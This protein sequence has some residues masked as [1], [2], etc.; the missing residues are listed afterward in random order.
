MT[1]LRV[2]VL[3]RDAKIIGSLVGGCRVTI[4]HEDT[5]Q[6]LARGLHLGGSGETDLIMKTPRDRGAG[7]VYDSPG[8]AC[9]EARL[10]LDGPTPIRVD[11][12]GPLA[13]PHA[14][15]RASKTLWMIPGE[16]IV[17]EG[18]LLELNGFIV[19]IL[20]PTGVDVLHSRAVVPVRAGV[21]LL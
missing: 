8:T 16:D 9:Y 17:G 3:S 20:Q 15:Q 2:R 4:R 13:F 1:R 18:L 12:E 14:I 5:G 19:E 6:V 7:R 10:D 11:V 21:R